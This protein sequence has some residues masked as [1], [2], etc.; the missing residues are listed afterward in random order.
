M[1][2]APEKPMLLKA[3]TIAGN[4]ITTLLKAFLL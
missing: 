4:A 2:V 1:T 3:G